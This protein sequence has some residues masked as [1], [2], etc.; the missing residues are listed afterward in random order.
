L[1]S[2]RDH[3]LA[4]GDCDHADTLRYLFIVSNIGNTHST[5]TGIVD[6]G[7]TEY[8]MRLGMRRFS[9]R[10]VILSVLLGSDPPQ[11][12]VAAL[13]D[14]CSLFDISPGTVRTALSRLAATGEVEA[15]DS[16]YVLTA[17]LLERRRQQEV[18]RLAPSPAWDGSWWTAV[19]LADARD[20]N[21]RRRFRS[22]MEGSKMGE[23][24]PTVW[25]RPT[26]IEPP[27]P[28]PDLM[29]SR[30][31]LPTA[32]GIALALRLWDLPALGRRADQL[33]AALD[34]DESG[35]AK[36]F[37]ALAACL[38]YL[39]TEPQLPAQLAW[40]RAAD[41]LRDRYASEEA[42]FQEDLKRFLSTGER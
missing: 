37:I 34:G 6:V 16:S 14:F 29:I 38:R 24:R 31:G 33:L 36:R 1:L 25:M 9:A 19:A 18:G 35:L 12:P 2:G 8:T 41:A 17:D 26:N 4:F 32:D 40:E 21:E 13:I 5:D 42:R 10:S 23:L 11:L 22:T 7:I 27:P 3:R 20:L 30:G 15:R 28:R 39:R